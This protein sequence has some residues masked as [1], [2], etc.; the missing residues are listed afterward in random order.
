MINMVATYDPRQHEILNPELLGWCRRVAEGVNDSTLATRLFCYH[1]RWH[2]TFVIGAWIAEPY[3]AFIDLMNL[4]TSLGTFTHSKGQE[5]IDRLY[6][7]TT[8]HQAAQMLRQNESDFLHQKQ[9][10]NEQI[11]ADLEKRGR[12]YGY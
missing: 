2:D 1:H 10:E 7:P 6:N 3:H 8:G 12:D 5:F 4:G 9:D 11:K